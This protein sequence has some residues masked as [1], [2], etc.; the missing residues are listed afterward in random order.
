MQLPSELSYGRLAGIA[1]EQPYIRQGVYHVLEVT[2]VL[3]HPLVVG[4]TMNMYISCV[5]FSGRTTLSSVASDRA[6]RTQISS[7]HRPL[8]R[9]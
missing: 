1:A 4:L 6:G 7:R 9:H 2:D 5:M 8:S 3:A